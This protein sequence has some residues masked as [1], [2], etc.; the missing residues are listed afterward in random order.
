MQWVREWGGSEH[1]GRISR[2]WTWDEDLLVRGRWV[3][4]RLVLRTGCGRTAADG[5][6]E[7][8][9]LPLRECLT[10]VIFTDFILFFSSPVRK[11][12]IHLHFITEETETQS[13]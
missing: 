2:G 8:H 9:K 6:Y 4:A 3:G 12:R 11:V 1:S 13:G 10:G 5:Y 7:E